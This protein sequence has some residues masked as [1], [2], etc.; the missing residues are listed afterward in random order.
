[1]L[2]VEYIS[3]HACAN[4][5]ILYRGEYATKRYVRNVGMTGTINQIKMVNRMVLLIRY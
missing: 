3:Y 2:G 4:E 5:C 1:M